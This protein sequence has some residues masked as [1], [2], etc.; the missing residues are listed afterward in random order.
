[1]ARRKVL[2][3]EVGADGQLTV[4]AVDQHG[5]LDGA[6]PAVVGQCIERGPHRAA[7]VEHVVDEHDRG[8]GELAGTRVTAPGTTGRRPMSSRYIDTS[9]APQG[10]SA[11]GSIVA[12]TAGQRSAS[13]RRRV[14]GR[15]ARRRRDH[16]SARRS[17]E[18]CG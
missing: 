3:H 5:E 6:G 12:I 1:V 4:A 16:G 2:A 10:T 11:A 7:G 15:P 14:A 18:R 17:R 13:Q 8:A 9:S